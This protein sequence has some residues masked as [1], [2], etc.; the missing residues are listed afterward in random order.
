MNKRFSTL[1]AAALVA[2]SFSSAFAQLEGRN[3][4]WKDAQA[5]RAYYLAGVHFVSP[6]DYL[7]AFSLQGLV[8]GADI[9][10]ANPVAA[11]QWTVETKK[12]GTVTHYA[13]KNIEGEQY[14]AFEKKDGAY[15]L[16][17]KKE[18]NDETKSF[19]WFTVAANGNLQAVLSDEKEP[20][21]LGLKN[22]GTADWS[23]ALL[24]SSEHHTDGSTSVIKKKVALYEIY[25][26][27]IT[28]EAFASK[29]GENF[30][31]EF[32][33]TL[34]DMD[35][36]ENVSV[37]KIAND[38]LGFKLVDNKGTK[39]T[40]DDEYVVLANE[41]VSNSE[42]AANAIGYRYA[43]MTAKA[44]KDKKIDDKNT[45]FYAEENETNIG[46]GKYA[47]VQKVKVGDLD[48][49]DVTFGK[50]TNDETTRQLAS[51]EYD[52]HSTFMGVTVGKGTRVANTEVANERMLIVNVTAKVADKKNSSALGLKN[53]FTGARWYDKVSEADFD[54][55]QGQWLVAAG[56]AANTIKLINVQK[57]GFVQDNIRLYEAEGE[58]T[59]T[60]FASDLG[61]SGLET[62]T[63]TKVEDYDKL[64]GYYS[65][66]SDI[67][68]KFAF[69]TTGEY[70]NEEAGSDLYLKA[71][72][73]GDVVTV[74]PHAGSEWELIRNEKAQA[75]TANYKYYDGEKWVELNGKGNEEKGIL[76]A[77]TV[78]LAYSYA[79]NADELGLGTAWK[80]AKDDIEFFLKESGKGTYAIVYGATAD[81]VKEYGVING[82]E[83][84]VAETTNF[85][86]STPFEIIDLDAA[87][88]LA[89]DSKH[90]TFEATNSIGFIASDE[91]NN[92]VLAK[93]TAALWVDSVNAEGYATPKFFISY[94]GKMMTTAKKFKEIVDKAY[95]ND[96]ISKK[97]YAELTAAENLYYKS[98][99]RI[100][101]VDAER[102]SGEDT[103][104]IAD[105]KYTGKDIED[106]KFKV[107]ENEDGDYV[108]KANGNYV[109]VINGNLV[110]GTDAKE[111]EAFVI[112]VTSAPTANEGIATSEVK[113]IAGEG[114]VTI[115]G[116]AGKKVVISN[117]L[118]QVVANTVVSSDNATI[119]AP[120]GVVVV[121]VEGEA[122]VKAIVK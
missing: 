80:M 112:E 115:S 87:P 18:A 91:N 1:L 82:S 101:F 34:D 75:V 89:A 117:I 44:I 92:A 98:V 122:A 102:L 58:N 114:N 13:F 73:E 64:N 28:A 65:T 67:N 109:Y 27:Q 119:A 107:T 111:A 16:A 53:D 113:V 2:G 72:V 103:L 49:K 76:P 36:F 121:A 95:A 70:A 4:E 33:E 105:E 77:D 12:V 104:V 5:S 11:A 35:V 63:L 23:L 45:V 88:S 90:M 86:N 78:R 83:E 17:A 29:F 59:Y 38:N 68:Q 25:N 37:E 118:G 61:L 48:N 26:D 79:I 47:L 9:T 24:Q 8:N 56:S 116:A 52:C 42:L 39:D 50:V 99:E 81:E 93:E 57:P 41:R 21:F 96:E 97:E 84:L 69:V 71:G 30:T 31:I 32:P 120:A 20:Y 55:P 110:Y 51:V 85:T 6:T 60:V 10:A 15:A 14:L 46:D 19:R 7:Q 3:V 100:K 74:V 106:F 108:L 40:K 62:I 43:K 66:L 94:A 22:D 54:Q